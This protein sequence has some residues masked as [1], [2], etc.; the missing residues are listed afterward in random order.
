MWQL[1]L[2]TTLNR[3]ASSSLPTEQLGCTVDLRKEGPQQ[4]DT[5][6][7]HFRP[8]AAGH[9]LAKTKLL[10]HWRTKVRHDIAVGLAR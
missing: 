2:S 8:G 9:N 7:D 5:G 1:W 10:H 4:R 3:H 6:V